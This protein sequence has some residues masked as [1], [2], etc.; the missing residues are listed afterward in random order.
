MSTSF[1]FRPLFT[2]G[3]FLSKG[4]RKR[5]GIFHALNDPA[6]FAFK[7]FS[8]TGSFFRSGPRLASSGRFGYKFKRGAG[9]KSR[10][11][12][13]GPAGTSP[14]GSLVRPAGTRKRASIQTGGFSEK[15]PG[16]NPSR[17]PAAA[18]L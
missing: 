7:G 1:P 4:F 6:A 16:K 17:M 10:P 3:L 12:I 9:R 13:F 2:G 18:I 8:V 5:V 15:R 14:A 11:G